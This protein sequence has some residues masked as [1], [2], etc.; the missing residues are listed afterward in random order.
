MNTVIKYSFM[1]MGFWLCL[2]R[3]KKDMFYLNYQ[4]KR[5]IYVYRFTVRDRCHASCFIYK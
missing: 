2:A 4:S 1:E 5:S 3:K